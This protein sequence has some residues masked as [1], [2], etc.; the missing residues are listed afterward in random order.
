MIFKILGKCSGK[1]KLN[2]ATDDLGIDDNIKRFD[3]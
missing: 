3:F 2:P 1:P